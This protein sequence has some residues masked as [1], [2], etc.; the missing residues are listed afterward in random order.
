M[1]AEHFIEGFFYSNGMA[2]ATGVDFDRI[3]KMWDI[4]FDKELQN[5]IGVK[6]G[7]GR[8]YGY[9]IIICLFFQ[10]DEQTGLIKPTNGHFSA[11]GLIV[12]ETNDYNEPFISVSK[13]DPI[14]SVNYQVQTNSLSN[15]VMMAQNILDSLRCLLKVQLI[16]HES[17]KN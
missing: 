4:E 6:Y 9:V 16:F 14:L 13:T 2:P 3:D 15:L 1:I 10:L 12:R 7:I 17:K 5:K 11:N 8:R